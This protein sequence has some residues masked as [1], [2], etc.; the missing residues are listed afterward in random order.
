MKK[1]SGQLSLQVLVIGAISMFLIAGF[2][3]WADVYVK[4]VSRDT[5]NSESFAIAEAGIEYYRW[6]LAHAPLDFKDGNATSTGPYIH[7][8][9]DK[10]GNR[11]GQFELVITPPA[12]GTTIVAIQSTGKVDYD[13][14]V[15]KVIKVR[16]GLPSFARYSVAANADIRFGEGTSIY[17]Q[18]HSN[19]GIRFDGVAYNTV[20]SAK[21]TYDDPDHDGANEFGVHTHLSPADPAPPA[22]VPV[23]TD[24]FKAGRQFPVPAIDFNG[25]TQDLATLRA[26]AT[27]TSGYYLASST[28]LGYEIILKTNDKF[29]VYKVNSVNS[30]ST[31]CRNNSTKSDSIWGS[32][33]INNKTLYASNVNFPA[34]GVIFV[35]DN[36]WVSGQINTARL[37]IGAGRFPVN[38]ST[39]ANITINSDLKYTNYD[40]QDVI[41]LISQNHVL[42]GLASEDDLR[43]DAA[44]IAQNGRVGRYHYANNCGSNYIRSLITLYGMVGTNLRYGWAW[45][46]G[47]GYTTRNITYDGNLL[48]GPP[49][50]FPITGSQYDIISWDE[51]K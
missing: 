28:V 13:P 50:S 32:W 41:G 35:E 15:R 30:V 47:T 39:Y 17:G 22:S 38:P 51:V 27:S 42:V 3:A 40:G 6:H 37:N 8:Y 12:T 26:L 14:T 33:S 44:V 16:M 43:I 24:V 9:Y 49:P 20:T 45:T 18:L 10:D 25:I 34:N 46:D 5:N 36:L 23:R 7:P 1:T 19:G 48:Y 31:A 29:D 2:V 11:V 4:S 21:T